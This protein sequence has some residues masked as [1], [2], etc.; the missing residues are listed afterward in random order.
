MVI[1]II[2][3]SVGQRV[4]PP[5]Y[6]REH[7]NYAKRLY[8]LGR[9]RFVVQNF[10]QFSETIGSCL[11]K[12]FDHLFVLSPDIV[13]INL[14][15]NECLT[16]L[17]PRCLFPALSGMILDENR[18]QKMIR[19]RVAHLINYYAAPRLISTFNLSPWYPMPVFKM[20]Y[21]KLIML[22]KKEFYPNIVCLGINPCTD[23]IEKLLPGSIANIPKYNAIIEQVAKSQGCS[24][25]ETESWIDDTNIQVL[26]P[27][28]IHLSAEGHNILATKIFTEIKQISCF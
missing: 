17:V 6:N 15:I 23:R 20:K 2:G 3:N 22:L 13:I 12:T 14:G 25:V 21:E 28:G 7:Q 10:C 8:E 11:N 4:R 26:V 5:A 9:G 19:D 18:L 16:R 27:D 24:F 1:A